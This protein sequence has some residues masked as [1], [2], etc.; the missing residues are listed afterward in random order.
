M[1]SQEHELPIPDALRSVRITDFGSLVVTLTDS[2]PI[3]GRSHPPIVV[4]TSD[5]ARLN[6][7]VRTL[8][9]LESVEPHEGFSPRDS[10]AYT[11]L[12]ASYADGHIDSMVVMQSGRRYV[13]FTNR[14]G[15][16]RTSPEL[17]A[18]LNELLAGP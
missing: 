5:P 18:Y 14:V 9:A 3:P 6:K 17:V 7:L 15:H 11:T 2:D 13:Y 1:T 10:G 8:N 12:D 4:T 16:W